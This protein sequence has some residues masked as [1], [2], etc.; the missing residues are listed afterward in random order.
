[1]G[2]NTG[3]GDVHNL[4][5]KILAVE[6][7]WAGD[8]LLDTYE[9]ERIP[10]AIANSLQSRQ[11]EANIHR[12]GRSV[13]G[14]DNRSVEERMAN[15]ET[16]QD[17]QDAIRGNSDHFDSLDLQLGYVYGQPRDAC[18]SISDF[19]PVCIPG[20]RLP[21]A[22]VLS[23]GRT[24]STLDAT[25]G[26]AFTLFTSLGFVEMQHLQIDQVPVEVVQ[27]GRAILDGQEDWTRLM[28]L[29][30]GVAGIL[31]RPDQHILARVHSI[32]EVVIVLRTFL[33]GV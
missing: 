19:H 9:T 27:V 8:S 16:R 4:V 30:D 26:H 21:H 22:W 29:Q 6:N 23:N 12:L 2:I 20:A 25:S 24:I 13:F 11:N 18:K 15:S 17:I 5:W 7:K 31:V 28:G 32:E 3:I 1:M 33:W 14:E 10:I